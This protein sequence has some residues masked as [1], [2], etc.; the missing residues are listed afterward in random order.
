VANLN[1]N[2]IKTSKYFNDLILLFHETM[3]NINQ[4]ETNNALVLFFCYLITNRNA[5]D[6]VDKYLDYI[7]VSLLLSIPKELGSLQEKIANS[8]VILMTRAEAAG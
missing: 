7:T 4:K 5:F 6:I 1:I 8:L 2:I 3:V